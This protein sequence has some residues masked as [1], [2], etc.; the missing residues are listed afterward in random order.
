[1]VNYNENANYSQLNILYEDNHIIAVFKPSGILVQGD[2]SD[3]ITLID[4][5]KK[6]LADKYNKTGNVFLGLVHRLDKPACGVV[7]F[8][9]TS[10]ASG[11]LCEQFRTHSIK[12]IYY[13]LVEGKLNNNK[14][15]TIK[16]YLKRK[17][18]K[19]YVAKNQKDKNLSQYAELNYR[20]LKTQN[21][22]SLL[23]IN[24]ITGRKH[25]IRTQLS[26]AG[27]PIVGDK[28]YG[29]K[30]TLNNKNA[31]ALLSKEIKFMHPTTKEIITITTD[32]P[33]EWK[34]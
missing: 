8:G 10:K 12:K 29:A 18:D 32:I 14:S 24:L 19:S 5:V 21:N 11:R 20:V 4:M 33:F 6:Y 1:M 31:I 22:I 26:E 9:K 15:N 7:L 27:F 13:A 34:F 16:S 23:E 28:K 25:Q 2:S 17:G 30:T 3:E